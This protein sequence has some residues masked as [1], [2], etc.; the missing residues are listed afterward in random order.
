MANAKIPLSYLILDETDYAAIERQAARDLKY[1]AKQARFLKSA[2]NVASRKT[3][4]LLAE[5]FSNYVMK[6]PNIK[7][8]ISDMELRGALGLRKSENIQNTIIKKTKKIFKVEIVE[9]ANGFAVRFKNPISID[10]VASTI[11]YMS[12]RSF[13]SPFSNEK[14]KNS[15]P[16]KIT[17]FEWLL[18]PSTGIIKGYSVWPG[19]GGN[20]NL[21]PKVEPL[22]DTLVANIKKRSRSGTHIMLFGGSFAMKNWVKKKNDSIID[23]EFIIEIRDKAASYFKKIVSEQ[24]I[25]A[26]ATKRKDVLS[27]KAV[28]VQASREASPEQKAEYSETLALIERELASGAETILGKTRKEIISILRKQGIQ[29][30]V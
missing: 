9:T 15:T 28:Q 19:V 22:R 8:A 6:H 12:K 7:Q 24:I 11:F 17:W 16:Q 13:Q 18:R 2:I 27:E 26:G 4:Q 14:S 23:Q 29:I 3:A 21:N 30:N 20:T 10:Q 25:K 1:V 5:E